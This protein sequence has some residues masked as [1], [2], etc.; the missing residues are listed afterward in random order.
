[1]WCAYL[2]RRKNVTNDFIFVE[3]INIYLIYSLLSS[4]G[5][6]RNPKYSICCSKG[7][8][9]LPPNDPLPILMS[10]LLENPDFMTKIRKYNAAF[11]F[12]TFNANSDQNL[13][14]NNIF[15][16]RIQG[17]IYHRIGPLLP[18]KDKDEICAQIY[19][20]G[21][22]E[23]VLRGKYSS[24]L[25]PCVLIQIQAMLNELNPFVCQF[26]KAA[27]LLKSKIYYNL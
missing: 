23:E 10:K 13:S 21:E 24:G 18:A 20:R 1:M 6:A 3:K 9:K 4:G 26:K 8:V 15:T 22:D 16:L 5:N 27:S 14:K 17:Q 7:K 11:S 12:I 19:F 25:N 2:G